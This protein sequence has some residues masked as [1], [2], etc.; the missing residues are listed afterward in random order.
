MVSISDVTLAE[1]ASGTTD[2][3][4]TVALDRPTSKQVIV[5]FSTQ[6]GTATAGT[7]YTALA[8]QTLTFSA[9]ETS[10]Q[11]TV[12]VTGDAVK[13]LEEKF[14][15]VLT[16]ASN[17]MIVKGDGTGTIQNDDDVGNFS[18]LVWSDEFNGTT[19][20]GD[21]WAFETGD[22]CPSICGWGNNEMEYYT[23]RPENLFF[24]G[25]N[26]VIEARKENFSGR[27]YTS[28]KIIS[29]GKKTF[30]FGKMEF[31]AKLPEGKGIWPDGV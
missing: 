14:S 18:I 1:G 11:I 7:D 9:N 5:N 2:F 12:A 13:E 22:G 21:N 28:A 15:V 27:Q 6:D 26:M 17:A 8:N 25:G 16:N 3:I 24:E 31:R 10:K 19:L 20:N 4:F 23:S 29:R 30:K